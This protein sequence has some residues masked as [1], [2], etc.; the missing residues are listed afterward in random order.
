[1]HVS[2]SP[3]CHLCTNCI[4]QRFVSPGGVYLIQG[5]A[6]KTTLLTSWTNS[7]L[8]HPILKPVLLFATDR[9]FPKLV[10]LVNSVVPC[11]SLFIGSRL[12][13]SRKNPVLV[14]SSTSLL[15]ESVRGALA[16]AKAINEKLSFHL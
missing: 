14:I 15:S 10:R 5:R 2:S 16:A 9:R 4:A 7:S 8:A 1:L 13:G 3:S 11:P 12:D 6:Y